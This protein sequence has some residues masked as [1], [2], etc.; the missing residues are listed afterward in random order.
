MSWLPVLTLILGA[1]STV[2]GGFAS[3]TYRNRLARRALRE[4]SDLRAA[5]ERVT[6]QKDTLLSLQAAGMNL[7]E[8][9]YRLHNRKCE[10]A[11]SAHRWPQEEDVEYGARQE[12]RVARLNAE[13]LAARVLDDDLRTSARRVLALESTVIRSPTQEE[14]NSRVDAMREQFEIA[15]DQLGEI[16]RRLI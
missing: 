4:E 8:A 16:L 9:T 11:R 5:T 12:H 10:L 13:I 6:F 3:E 1:I 15:N 2:V 7:L 14:A